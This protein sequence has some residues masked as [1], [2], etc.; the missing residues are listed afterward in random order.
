MGIAGAFNPRIYKNWK[1][2]GEL[3]SESHEENRYYHVFSAVNIL[4]ISTTIFIVPYLIRLFVNNEQYYESLAYLPLL[5]AAFV[6]KSLHTIYLN[7]I[8]YFKRTNLLPTILVVTA[9][10]QIISGIVLINLFGIWGAVWSYFLVRPIQV[11]LLRY[12]AKAFFRFSF[13]PIKIFWVP[14][15]YVVGVIVLCSTNL[16]EFEINA[17]QLAFAIILILFAYKN[18][19][20]ALPGMFKNV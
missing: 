1:S 10:V 4:I 9:V 20:K 5:C 6:F 7:P 15:F 13:N 18:E 17:A 12:K 19:I 8:M 2:K 3:V 11:L 14:M 16:T